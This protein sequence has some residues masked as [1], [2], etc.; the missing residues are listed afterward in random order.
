MKLPPEV[1]FELGARY[2]LATGR[3]DTPRIGATF[4]ADGGDYRPVNGALR[5]VRRG[6]FQQLD[7]RAEKTWLFER[8]SLGLYVDVQNVTNAANVEARQWDYRF[9]QS[10]PVTGIPLL[11]T[12]GVRGTW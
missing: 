11:P 7:L 3:P 4:D 8:W 12:I 1:S 10:A 5:S 6:T 2:Q 9:R